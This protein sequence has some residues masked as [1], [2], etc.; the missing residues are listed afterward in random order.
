MTVSNHCILDIVLGSLIT[1]LDVCLFVNDMCC[2]SG[3]MVEPAAQRQTEYFDPVVVT[4]VHL[5]SVVAKVFSS[6][7]PREKV[8]C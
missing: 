2:Q 5:A 8:A 6:A 1:A 7:L 4:T 3:A